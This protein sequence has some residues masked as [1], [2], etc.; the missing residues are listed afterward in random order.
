MSQ[1]TWPKEREGERERYVIMPNQAACNSQIK[2]GDDVSS[3]KVVASIPHVVNDAK[4]PTKQPNPNLTQ[5]SMLDESENENET[6][7]SE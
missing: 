5:T 2:G 7:A 3:P 4:I 1:V 6:H